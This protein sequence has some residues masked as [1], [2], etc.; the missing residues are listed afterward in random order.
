MSNAIKKTNTIQAEVSVRSDNTNKNDRCRLMHLFVATNAQGLW[1]TAYS[2]LPREELDAREQTSAFEHLA[3]L[4]NDYDNQV[5][6]N[7]VIRYDESGLPITPWKSRPLFE[8][9]SKLCWDLNPQDSTR[10][11][12]D[13]EWIRS[14]AGDMRKALSVCWKCYRTS[15]NQEAENIYSEWIKFYGGRETVNAYARAIFSD[16]H[17]NQLGKSMPEEAGLDT[18]VTSLKRPLSSSPSAVAK[19]SQRQ[20]RE[21]SAS[22]SPNESESSQTGIYETIKSVSDD[23]KKQTAL[24]HV[25]LYDPDPQFKEYA[26]NELRRQA[27]IVLIKSSIV[28]RE[29]TEESLNITSVEEV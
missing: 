12:R 17:F 6:K 25:S 13:A 23:A 21:V 26:W 22:A 27:G 18:Q 5:Y 4:F 29:L 15:G 7:A 2:P 24:Q 20:R 11:T 16:F 19:R 14:K 8:A 9:I 10:P 28:E 1:T 3:D